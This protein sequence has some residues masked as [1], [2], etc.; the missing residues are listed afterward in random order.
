M[1]REHANAQT[2]AYARVTTL[3]FLSLVSINLILKNKTAI[4]TIGWV[5][6]GFIS[7]A[8]PALGQVLFR[9]L[10]GSPYSLSSS[11][12]EGVG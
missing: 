3:C 9:G 8:G 6:K 10:M 4:K 7:K 11:D 2:L 5:K 12:G 1:E